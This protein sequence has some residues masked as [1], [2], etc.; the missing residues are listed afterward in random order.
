MEM[1]GIANLKLL[2]DQA[3]IEMDNDSVKTK[4]MR[5]IEEQV[6]LLHKYMGEVF[7][8]L[9]ENNKTLEGLGIEPKKVPYWHEVREH[10]EKGE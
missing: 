6:D 4:T 8:T 2:I 7:N 10:F 3:W 5:N 9:I 1:N